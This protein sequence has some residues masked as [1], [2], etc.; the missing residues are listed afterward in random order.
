[1]ITGS[2]ATPNLE[3]RP[4]E[5]LQPSGYLLHNDTL[6]C[7]QVCR[8]HDWSGTCDQ[9]M[10]WSWCPK[11]QSYGLGDSMEIWNCQYWSTLLAHYAA[12]VSYVYTRLSI[13]KVLYSLEVQNHGKCSTDH[14]TPAL[15]TWR[16]NHHPHCPSR[17]LR[18]VSW[19]PCSA[20]WYNNL[21][22]WW[23]LSRASKI[24]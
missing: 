23:L 20:T 3:G 7:H 11:W 15:E 2:Q 9:R 21:C 8:S 5:L 12:N 1:M 10:S 17:I 4:T 14:L 19:H 16:N 24:A 6:P 22:P 13:H 18:L